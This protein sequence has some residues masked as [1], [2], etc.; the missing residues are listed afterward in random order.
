[1]KI[2][3]LTIGL[4]CLCYGKVVSQ[5]QELDALLPQIQSIS[6]TLFFNKAIE[7][8]RSLVD[9]ER[10]AIADQYSD[11]LI[12]IAHKIQY[13]KG[14]G[15]AYSQKAYSF[16]E[17]DQYP[18]A[19]L[20]YEKGIVLFGKIDDAAGQAFVNFNISRIEEK[21]GNYSK[22][23]DYLMKANTYY[24]KNHDTIILSSSFNNLA[25]AYAGLGDFELARNYYKKSIKLSKL[26][27]PSK[28]SILMNNLALLYVENKIVD[29]AKVLL[30][31][32]LQIGK[33][34]NNIRSVAQSYSI[35]AKVALYN[36]E[37]DKSQKYY[38]STLIEGSKADWKILLVNAK[39]QMGLIAL[40]RKKY[41]KA[42][43]LLAIARKEFSALKLAPLLLKN[44]KF[45][46]KLDSTR[47]DFIKAFEWQKK[48]LELSDKRTSEIMSKK[49]EKAE[50]R[51]KEELEYLRL[52]DEQEKEEQETKE[53]LFQ[54]R[55]FSFVTL[56]ILLII[57]VFL[58]L[59]I[60]ARK[61]R[62]CY[63][64]E[65]N[66]SNQIKNKLFSI[67]SH[68]LKNEIHGLEGSLNLL[69]DNSISTE[70]F[71]EIVPLLA[72]RTHQTSIL[73]NNLL[74]WSKSQLKE[75]NAKP[76]TFD[77]TEVICDKFKF[78]NAK[79]EQ[80]NIKLINKLHPTTIY[81]DKDMFAIV[82]QNLIANAI[83]FCNSGDSITLLS[84]EKDK[85]YEICFQDTGI[86]INP[87]HMDKLFAEETFTT[88]GT[89][90][91]SG[92]GLGL[93]I[94]NELIQLNNGKIEV[95]STLGQG[96]TF[97]VLLPKAA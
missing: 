37:F 78:F 25:N 38:D 32:S 5:T 18:K 24:E 81:A 51:H 77:I 54:Y 42:D 3:R 52:I 33:Q 36:K 8:L 76:T 20:N 27:N 44:Y 83:K 79:A 6:D 45:S 13:T 71:K 53:A 28:V 17:R 89:Q 49:I 96:S 59:I 62:K 85:Y 9:K 82:S 2:F 19:L 74:N 92:T 95:K 12:E 41:K 93:K 84:Q 64:K 87:N 15:W 61:E 1:M 91:E 66:T 65:L 26:T 31:E 14:M 7:K 4:I 58:I 30:N 48:Y 23:I 21:K 80:K 46:I 55:V 70:E 22:S 57:L 86:G 47:G 34:N 10:Y 73:L 67:I 68:D 60:R 75:L 97:C 56:G 88:I 94:C 29:S 43:S 35:L 63:I 11:Q 39:Q 69:N 50:E 40:K 72:N 90:N 16:H